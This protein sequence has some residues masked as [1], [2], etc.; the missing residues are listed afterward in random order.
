MHMSP[1]IV[2]RTP[3]L[4][5]HVLVYAKNNW[6]SCFPPGG[7]LRSGPAYLGPGHPQKQSE[8]KA[9]KEME[10]KGSRTSMLNDT[11]RFNL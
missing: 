1:Q 5:I 8:A 6:W 2:V 10:I 11:S 3:L 4:G 9:R 7:M